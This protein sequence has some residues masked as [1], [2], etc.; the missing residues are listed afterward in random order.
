MLADL[1]LSQFLSMPKRAKR[2]VKSRKEVYLGFGCFSFPGISSLYFG[3]SNL[4]FSGDIIPISSV[5][6]NS[7]LHEVGL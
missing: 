1:V 2:D 3:D 5:E 7:L 6:A 4:L